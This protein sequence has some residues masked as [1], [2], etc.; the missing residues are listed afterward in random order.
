MPLWRLENG[1]EAVQ[2]E[3]PDVSQC[4]RQAP[5]LLTVDLLT[6]DLLTL[7]TASCSSCLTRGYY[8][9]GAMRMRTKNYLRRCR[10]P[11][12]AKARRDEQDREATTVVLDA[13]PVL[14]L[15]SHI[16]LTKLITYSQE[17]FVGSRQGQLH[18]VSGRT[19]L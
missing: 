7:L 10:L 12:K 14:L 19:R 18:T 8:V 9:I 4:K 5:V 3:N 2:R 16:I 15:A 13:R 1:A 17:G 6:V 11:T